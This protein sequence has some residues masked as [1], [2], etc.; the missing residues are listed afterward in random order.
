M[1]QVIFLLLITL[2]L[3][4]QNVK[5]VVR[6]SQT[7][8]NKKL[9]GITKNDR[10][11]NAIFSKNDGMNGP[12]TM[13]FA[14]DYDNLNRETRSYSAHSNVGYSVLE[15]AYD[16]NKV[17]WYEFP[18]DTTQTYSFDRDVLNE[19][20]SKEAFIASDPIQI[21]LQ[22]QKRLFGIDILNDQKNI[23]TSYY[24]S[25]KGDTTSIRT[26]RYDDK[27]NEVFFHLEDYGSDLWNWDIYSIYDKNS[28]LIK[29][30]RVE[31]KSNNDTTEVREY[32]YNDKNLRISEAYFNR[33][34]LY[35]RTEYTY[36]KAGRLT[37]ELFYE[38]DFKNP[39]SLL[40]YKYD[41]SGELLQTHLMHYTQPRKSRKTVTTF[42][43]IY[44]DK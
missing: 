40:T 14:S 39:R 9:T 38:E 34:Q 6:L 41:K 36:D 37:T 5:P 28:N 31:P 1:K 8:T 10:N 30:Y 16:G 3:F 27:N 33:G 35:N 32:Q 4:A 21:L 15:K 2:Q 44:W 25:E 26:Y 11:G 12:I 13:I 17:L 22:Q 20:D 42:K 29:S 7:F 43:D 23:V 24:V 18:A 19:F